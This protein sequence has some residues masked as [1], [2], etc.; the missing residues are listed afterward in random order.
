MSRFENPG[1]GYREEVSPL[2]WLWVLL[3]GWVYMLVKGLWGHVALQVA[4][5]FGAAL[6]SGG[7]GAFIGIP[8]WLV[9]VFAAKGILER[10]YLRRG[11]KQ[12]DV[13]D[14]IASDRHR[15]PN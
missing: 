1:N 15:F 6:L 14:P 13:D 8:L 11:W 9:Y 10:R 3:F 4:L 5:I 2:T 12:I 7:P